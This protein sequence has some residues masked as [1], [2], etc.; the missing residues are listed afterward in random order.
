MLN[1]SKRA[2]MIDLRDY[3]PRHFVGFTIWSTVARSAVSCWK[4]KT[5]QSDQRRMI[6]SLRARPGDGFLLKFRRR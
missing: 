3:D 5:S 4:T 2:I 6:Y 1:E